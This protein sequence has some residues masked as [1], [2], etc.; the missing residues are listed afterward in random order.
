MSADEFLAF[1]QVENTTAQI[2]MAYFWTLSLIIRDYTMGAS[3]LYLMRRTI[4]KAWVANISA[5]LPS[6]QRQY[7]QL[8]MEIVKKL[9]ERPLAMPVAG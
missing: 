4:A 8:P 7:L 1:T 5:T 6:N 3:N 9:S 2:L